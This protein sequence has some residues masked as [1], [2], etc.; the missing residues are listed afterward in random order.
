PPAVS[1]LSLHDALPISAA[2]GPAGG[3][4]RLAGGRVLALVP[5]PVPV[6]VLGVP[7]AVAPL[8]PAV[9]RRRG[10]LADGPLDL[11]AG[12]HRDG[13]LVDRKSTRLNSS[14]VKIS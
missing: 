3:G 4:R 8:G 6:L 14:H 2:L 5:V 7:L 1:A 9:G 10:R 12:V 13:E 11:L